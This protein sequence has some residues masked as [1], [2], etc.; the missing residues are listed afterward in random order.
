MTLVSWIIVA[1]AIVVIGIIWLVA[2]RRM[3]GMPPA[4]DDRPGLDLPDGDLSADDLQG[5]RFA[6]VSRGYSMAQVDALIDRLGVQ[7]GG[8]TFAPKSEFETWL[9]GDQVPAP[10]AAPNGWVAG[11]MDALDQGD[12]ADQTAVVEPVDDQVPAADV[13]VGADWAP[14][15]DTAEMPAVTAPADDLSVLMGTGPVSVEPWAEPIPAPL[16]PPAE[17]PPVPVVELPTIDVPVPP[18]PPVDVPQ[19]EV[20]QVD[21]PVPPEPPV[22]APTPPAVDLPPEPPVDVPVSPEPLPPTT[23]EG[24]KPPPPPTPEDEITGD[25]AVPSG[26]TPPQPVAPPQPV[27]EKA[28]PE[29]TSEFEAQMADLRA[30]AEALKA[31]GA[32]G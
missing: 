30:A 14:Q 26:P 29:H 28:V 1:V 13:P 31:D 3:G 2:A 6:V 11:P 21:V 20:P 15:A 7:L 8:G 9:A 12:Q 18:E 27:V 23:D 19:V 16:E 24:P 4:V 10:D 5:V 25:I 17:V 32:I 22:E